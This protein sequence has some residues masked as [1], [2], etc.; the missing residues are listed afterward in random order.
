MPVT[1]T[2]TLNLN[3]DIDGFPVTYFIDSVVLDPGTYLILFNLY[4]F[5][6]NVQGLSL[7]TYIGSDINGGSEVVPPSGVNVWQG[8]TV[9]SVLSYLDIMCTNQQVINLIS[10]TTIYFNFIIANSA[11][12]G[13]LGVNIGYPNNS[14]N[15]SSINIIKLM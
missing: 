12:N 10:Q 14:T 4:M 13:I 7:R 5:G 1:Q 15:A 3:T 11:Y 2:Y 9:N 8:A 6:T